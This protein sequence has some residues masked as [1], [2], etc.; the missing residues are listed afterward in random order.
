MEN[1]SRLKLHKLCTLWESFQAI[2]NSFLWWKIQLHGRFLTA[3]ADPG[4]TTGASQQ[5]HSGQVGAQERGGGEERERG[6]FTGKCGSSLDA[7]TIG[8]RWP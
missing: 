6:Y 2:A 4:T 1:L 8:R 5:L 3:V 7:L